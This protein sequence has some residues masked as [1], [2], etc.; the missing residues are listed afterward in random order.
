M[1]AVTAATGIDTDSE[2]SAFDSHLI[3]EGLQ[4][5]PISVT[6]FEVTAP[7]A[8]APNGSW[9]VFEPN[10]L[11]QPASI[12]WRTVLVTLPFDRDIHGNP[13]INAAQD[14]VANG[15]KTFKYHTLEI[16][17]NKAFYDYNTLKA[18]E[19]TVNSEDFHLIDLGNHRIDFPEGSV[20]CVSIQPARSY[21]RKDKYVP[22]TYSLEIWEINDEIATTQPHQYRFLNAG[23]NGWYDDNG[24][25]KPGRICTAKGDPV[26]DPVRLD[27]EGKPLDA[28]YKIRDGTSTNLYSPVSAPKVLP[29][30]VAI[31]TTTDARY[32]VWKRYKTSNFWTILPTT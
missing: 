12:Q 1:D 23:V 15:T 28:T 3:C 21:T 19:N 14:V 9:E 20:K 17:K 31:E 27:S 13:V 16:T 24:T 10:P 30:A 2:F 32:L 29:D 5:R 7:Y 11:S 26:S 4:A 8:V 25:R 6:V 18:Y 22:I